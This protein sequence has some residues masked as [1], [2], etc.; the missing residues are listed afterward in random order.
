MG[1]VRMPLLRQGGSEVS[2]YKI[3]T[4]F[5]GPPIPERRF[6]WVAWIDG[7][8]DGHIG[9][10]ATEEASVRDLVGLIFDDKAEEHGE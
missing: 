4:V 8:E 7:R 5:D 10:G 2:V 1:R 3:V 9:H 6:D